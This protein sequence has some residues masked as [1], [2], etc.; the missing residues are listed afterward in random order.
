[1]VTL[2]GLDGIKDAVGRELGVSDWY[3]VT[4]ERVNAF[5]DATDDYQWI[6][7]EPERARDVARGGH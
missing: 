4:Q 5:A 6:H 7:V 2:T 1:M 3:E